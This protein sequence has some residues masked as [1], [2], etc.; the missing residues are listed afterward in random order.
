MICPKCYKELEIE[1]IFLAAPQSNMVYRVS[2]TE[3]N[4]ITDEDLAGAAEKECNYVTDC[5]CGNCKES[6]Y[7]VHWNKELR[8]QCKELRKK[9]VD[10]DE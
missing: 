8:D 6:V 10:K 4:L 9:D 2:P 1:Q 3:E 5:Y 7:F